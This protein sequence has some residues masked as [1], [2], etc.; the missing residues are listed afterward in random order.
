M[1]FGRYLREHFYWL[2]GGLFLILTILIF[3][4]TIKGSIYLMIY[5]AVAVSL[6]ISGGLY[7]DYHRQKKI[8]DEVNEKLEQLEKKYLIPEVVDLPETQE[9]EALIHSIL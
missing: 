3:L 2:L 4:L 5:V 8:Y 6:V 7:V 9:A 1:T